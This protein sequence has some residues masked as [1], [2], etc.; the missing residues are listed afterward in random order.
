MEIIEK[1]RSSGLTFVEVELVEDTHHQRFFIDFNFE[2]F[3]DADDERKNDVLCRPADYLLAPH[4]TMC[5]KMIIQFI[6]FFDN[7]N[8][9]AR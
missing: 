4:D 3:A 6:S 9:Q 8:Y 1:K 5:W 7:D 2:E